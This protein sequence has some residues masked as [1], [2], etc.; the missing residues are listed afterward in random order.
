MELASAFGKR[1]LTQEEFMA[2]AYG[3]TEASS[4][5]TDQVSSILNAA[6]TSKWGVIQ[7]TGVLWTWGQER[8]GPYGAASWNANTEGRGSEYAAPNASLFGGSWP[9]TSDSGS[10]ASYWYSAASSS[11]PYIGLRAACDH[12]QLV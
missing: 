7:S 6:Y 8:G 5:G 2:A 11:S 3:T 9:I 1:G 4:V 12:L 10:R